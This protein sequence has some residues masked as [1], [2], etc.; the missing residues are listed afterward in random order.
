MRCFTRK[1]SSQPLV[2]A[3]LPAHFL[4]DARTELDHQ[5]GAAKIACD[6]QKLRSTGA[7]KWIKSNGVAAVTQPEVIEAERRDTCAKAIQ[8]ALGTRVLPML[9]S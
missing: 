4:T 2:I 8:K 9:L 6:P 5:Y 7:R 3:S 1:Q